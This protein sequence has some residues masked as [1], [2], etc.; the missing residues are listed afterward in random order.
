LKTRFLVIIPLIAISVV[1]VLFVILPMIGTIWWSSHDPRDKSSMDKWFDSHFQKEHYDIEI[2]GMKDVYLLG[3]KYDF[4]YIISGYGYECGSKKVI[5]PDSDGDTTGIFSS[6]SCAA[7]LPMKN[8]V[9]DAQ[10]ETGTTF[11]HVT[12]SKAGHYIVAVEFEQSDNFEPTQKGHDFFVV[13]KICNDISDA[14]E[15][16]KCIVDSFDSCESAYLAQRFPENSGGTVSVVAVVESW[17]DCRL[18]VY[19]ENSLSAHTPYNGIRSMCDD[20]RVDEYSLFFEGCNN[21]EYPPISLTHQN[22]RKCNNSLDQPDFECFVDSFERCNP[23]TIFVTRYTIEGDPIFSSGIVIATDDSCFL[24]FVIDTRQDRFGSQ[25]IE[26]RIC[27]DVT[28][29]KEMLTFHCDDGGIG[30]PLK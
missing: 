30:V 1:A 21:A 12:L 20:V 25:K 5:F 16:A 22:P 6:S 10:R 19:P 14:K 3:E 4:S 27:S 23:A 26:H 8:F 24:D 11:G 15:Q 17:N 2:T 29:D 18:A 9:F 13:E 7:N 28:L